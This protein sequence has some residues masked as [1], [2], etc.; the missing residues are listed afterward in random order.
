M[1]MFWLK[2]SKY[3]PLKLS[4]REQSIYINSGRG[5]PQTVQA[6]YLDYLHVDNLGARQSGINYLCGYLNYI[7][8][9]VCVFVVR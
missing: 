1:C 8:H 5:A 6:T 3:V 7:V 4:R 2:F 9:D